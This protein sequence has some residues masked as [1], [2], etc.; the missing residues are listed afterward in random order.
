[1]CTPAHEKVEKTLSAWFLEVR[2]KNSP[3]DGPMLMAKA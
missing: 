1:M 3:V 2:A